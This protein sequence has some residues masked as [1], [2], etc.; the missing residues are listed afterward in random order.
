M[1]V[2][3]LRP[4]VNL[5][6]KAMKLNRAFVWCRVAGAALRRIPAPAFVVIALAAFLFEVPAAPAADALG[7]ARAAADTD[8]TTMRLVYWDYSK[9]IS[10]IRVTRDCDSLYSRNAWHP[11]SEWGPDTNEVCEAS[12]YLL[13]RNY[14]RGN[15]LEWIGLFHSERCRI[16]GFIHFTPLR[17]DLSEY[18]LSW[19]EEHVFQECVNDR[20]L[21]DCLRIMGRSAW[22][23]ERRGDP[24]GSQTCA[25]NGDILE[26]IYSRDRAL[27]FQRLFFN[28]RCQ[29]LGLPY[30]VGTSKDANAYYH[31]TDWKWGFSIEFPAEWKI[32][33]SGGT[34]VR[35]KVANPNGFICSVIVREA[36]E[37]L[38][39][40]PARTIYEDLSAKREMRREY[41][42]ELAQTIP[43]FIVRPPKPDH[44]I[45]GG[46][47]AHEE[48]GIW[49]LDAVSDFSENIGAGSAIST[50][51]DSMRWIEGRMYKTSCIAD[52]KKYYD[53]EHLMFMFRDSMKISG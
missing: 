36:P 32:L 51:S 53:L 17:K 18:D 31:F 46:F 1:K 47:G 37:W 3:Y 16:L 33:S 6:D 4:F 19:E 27:P 14:K 52:E 7:G 34:D 23:P 25:L 40:D 22:M 15:V 44:I 8:Q 24:D 20:N 12:K 13:E 43:G 42:A 49:I 9:C 21:D 48:D 2:R 39:M 41:E 28:E 10:V 11:D 29:R 50:I 35:L 5:G 26:L 38:G 30:F 45:V